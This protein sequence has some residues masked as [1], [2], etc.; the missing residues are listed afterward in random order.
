M[1]DDTK[2]TLGI[3]VYVVTGLLLAYL[4]DIRWPESS[5]AGGILGLV[6]GFGVIFMLI[7]SGLALRFFKWV[8]V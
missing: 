3:V 1:N 2:W 8:G 7:R 4:A 6:F 5:T